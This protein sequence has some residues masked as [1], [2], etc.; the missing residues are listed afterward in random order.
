MASLTGRAVVDKK[1]PN[2]FGTR[3]AAKP[4]APAWRLEIVFQSANRKLPVSPR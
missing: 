2:P 4:S 3:A 1:C